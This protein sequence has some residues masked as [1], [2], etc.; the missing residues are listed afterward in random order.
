MST[1]EAPSTTSPEIQP[2]DDV[3]ANQPPQHAKHKNYKGFVAGM[4][5]GIAKLSGL[6][7]HPHL[8]MSLF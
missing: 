2:E 8:S 1:V 7:L 3:V 6:P 4:A 5:S